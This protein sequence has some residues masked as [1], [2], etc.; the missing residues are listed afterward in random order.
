MI[1]TMLEF[2]TVAMIETMELSLVS[3]VSLCIAKWV[4]TV[5]VMSIEALGTLFES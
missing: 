3:I 5:T 2:V 4:P 1:K